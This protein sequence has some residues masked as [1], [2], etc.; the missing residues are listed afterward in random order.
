MTAT[1]SRA[2][3]YVGPGVLAL[4]LAA[5]LS[6]CRGPAEAAPAPAADDGRASGAALYA[7][8][9]AEC[10]GARLEGARGPSLLEAR[11]RDGQGAATL[12]VAIRQ[13][14]PAR[15]MPG[16]EG[17]LPE[18][19]LVALADHVFAQ[20]LQGLVDGRR[21][22]PAVAV[23]SEPATPR[24]NTALRSLLHAFRISTLVAD[25]LRQPKSLAILP[26]GDLLVT[27]AAGLRRAGAPGWVL[28][29]AVQGLPEY[30]VLEEVAAHPEYP[31]NGWLYLTS[32]C[33]AACG[34]PDRHVY[35]LF[36]GRIRDGRWVDGS[37]LATYGDGDASYGVSKLAFDGAG[38]LWLSLSGAERPGQDPDA[39]AADIERPASLKSHRGKIFRLRDD[40]AV[41]SDGPFADQQFADRRITNESTGHGTVSLA[42]A[43]VWS[44]GHRGLSGL[45]YD[46]HTRTLWATEHGPWGGDELNRIVRGGDYGWPRTSY[47]YHYG[48][49]LLEHAALPGLEAPVFH[50]TPS[51]GVSGVL[52]YRGD[53]FPQWRGDLFVGALGDRIGRTLYRFRL[54]DGQARLYEYP[55]DAD[56]RVQRDAA[57]HA[58][59]RV[60]RFEEVAADIGRIR[61]LREGPD[62]LIYLLLENPDRILRLEPAEEPP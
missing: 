30:D 24:P 62:G 38:Y 4:G 18:A 36:R 5:L 41:P 17:V 42:P 28:G 20:N 37:T 7:T 58:L 16:F 32:V 10:H 27:D 54:V 3:A 14:V 59:P 48:G 21:G 2:S 52:V 25:G 57:G 43:A 47:G 31:S 12:S 26:D 19:A 11:W 51:A 29:G 56:G 35:S 50:W 40:G 8:Y 33:S 22:S 60:A 55:T 46:R 6:V 45:H 39:F 1:G 49:A 53:A 15:G 23:G 44:L 9:C 13:G 61:D 34:H